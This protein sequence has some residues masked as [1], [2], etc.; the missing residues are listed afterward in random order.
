MEHLKYRFL[1]PSS[2]DFNS[3]VLKS[4]PGFYILINFP[5]GPEVAG[6]HSLT[7]TALSFTGVWRSG[8]SR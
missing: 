7:H 8:V 6:D 4:G 5:G 3:A 2:R 1:N